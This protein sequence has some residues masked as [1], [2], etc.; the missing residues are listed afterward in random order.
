M[1]IS[2]AEGAPC[3]CRISKTDITAMLEGKG[4]GGALHT[5]AVLFPTIATCEAET[6]VPITVDV[7]NTS[8]Q[9]NLDVNLHS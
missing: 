2:V 9:Y 5:S 3:K 4:H 8:L 7:H 6:G 1:P